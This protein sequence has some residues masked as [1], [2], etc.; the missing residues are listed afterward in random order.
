MLVCCFCHCSWL[1]CHHLLL[2][3]NGKLQERSL[4]QLFLEME[5]Q[6]IVMNGWETWNRQRKGWVSNKHKPCKSKQLVTLHF[7]SQR[8]L[9]NNI[10]YDSL[11][12]YMNWKDMYL[13]LTV[14][15]H[16]L[17]LRKAKQLFCLC[18]CQKHT[19]YIKKKNSQNHQRIAKVKS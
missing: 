19:S 11:I 16:S 10:L 1:T 14:T 8:C 17:I 4:I 13:S 6:L 2:P 12:K 18:Y 7:Q 15:I 9:H 5:T 3:V